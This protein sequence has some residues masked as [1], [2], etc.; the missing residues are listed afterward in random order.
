MLGV[1]H[2]HPQVYDRYHLEDMSTP[3]EYIKWGKVH[4]LEFVEFADMAENLD[5]HYSVVSV[6]SYESS[7]GRQIQQYDLYP[8]LIPFLGGV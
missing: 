3:E 7:S 5:K 4:G 8:V 1:H 6:L 2:H